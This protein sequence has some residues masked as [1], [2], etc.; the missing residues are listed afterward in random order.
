MAGLASA[1][2][3]DAPQKFVGV[4]AQSAFGNVTS[5]S[6]GVEAGLAV[7]PAFDVFLEGGRVF[8]AAPAS[9]GQSAQTIAGFLSATQASVAY[10]VKEPVTFFDVAARYKIHTSGRFAPYLL[11]G[12]GLGQ[13][14]PDAQFTIG[15]T[16]VNS[17]LD[18][19]GVVLGSDLSGSTTKAMMM[20][21]AGVRYPLGDRFYADAELRYNRVFISSGAIPFARAGL[22]LGI[23][24]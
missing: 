19:Y 10:T 3:V 24:F 5:Q 2:A 23:Q 12:I 15:G 17:K 7:T 11:A 4:T 18:Q 13:V 16:S 6:F 21:G 8:D 14:K 1:Q 22:G 9:L 20:V